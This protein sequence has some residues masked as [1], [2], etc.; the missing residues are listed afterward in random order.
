MK[1]FH[2]IDNTINTNKKTIDN[3]FS[4]FKSKETEDEKVDDDDR[5]NAALIQWK[6]LKAGV[7]EIKDKERRTR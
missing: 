6:R 3:I 1:V 5:Y 2:Y 4:L 7:E